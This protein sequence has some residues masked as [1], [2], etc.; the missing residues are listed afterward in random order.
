VNSFI[1]PDLLDKNV[2]YDNTTQIYLVILLWKLG[3]GLALDFAL[4]IRVR[5]SV[6]LRIA[7]L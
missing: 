3:L 1:E 5:I 4:E 2:P 6:R 7:L